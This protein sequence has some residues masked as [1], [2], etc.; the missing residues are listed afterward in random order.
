MLGCGFRLGY[1][2][3]PHPRLG[4]FTIAQEGRRSEY[5]NHLVTISV[6]F[7]HNHVPSWECVTDLYHYIPKNYVYCSL[8]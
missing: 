3:G 7:E 6:P 5:S 1:T 2:S 8:V 4:Y